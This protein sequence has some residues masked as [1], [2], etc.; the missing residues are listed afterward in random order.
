RRQVRGEL[1]SLV[2]ELRFPRERHRLGRPSEASREVLRRGGFRWAMSRPQHREE[3]G[4]LPPTVGIKDNTT[5]RSFGKAWVSTAVRNSSRSAFA[6]G[7]GPARHA[8]SEFPC[9][10]LAPKFAHTKIAEEVG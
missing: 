2:A 10:Q 4:C 3:N 6:P 1:T 7:S 5:E 9:A 8:G